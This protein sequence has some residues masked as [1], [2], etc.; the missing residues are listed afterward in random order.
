V[1][2][3]NVVPVAAVYPLLGRRRGQITH[4]DHLHNV[5]SFEFGEGLDM[6]MGQRD[7]LVPKVLDIDFPM[8]VVHLLLAVAVVLPKVVGDLLAVVVRPTNAF[9]SVD[10]SPMDLLVAEVL[11]IGQGRQHSP[12]VSVDTDPN[13][14]EQEDTL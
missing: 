12:K 13:Y 7:G 14:S 9:D 8:V 6:L 4:R 1:G 2:Y 11:E 10:V 3:T 5:V